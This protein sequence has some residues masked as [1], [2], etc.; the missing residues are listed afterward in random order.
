MN[1]ID[2]L[3]WTTRAA[4]YWVGGLG[5]MLGVFLTLWYHSFAVG[6]AWWVLPALLL[7]LTWLPFRGVYHGCGWLNEHLNRFCQ[8]CEDHFVLRRWRKMDACERIWWRERIDT[9]VAPKWMR[10]AYGL[11]QNLLRHGK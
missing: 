5:F 1:S 3:H 4:L 8:S 7:W 2:E 11:E 10:L 9:R 6:I